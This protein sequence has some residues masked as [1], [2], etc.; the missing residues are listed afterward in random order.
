MAAGHVG[1]GPG[2]VDEH[3][4]FGIEIGLGIEPVLAFPQDIRA[5][6]LGRMGGIFFRVMR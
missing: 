5:I 6:L 1:R 2:L 4:P 3:E